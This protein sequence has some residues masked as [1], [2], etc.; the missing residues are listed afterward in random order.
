M[1]KIDPVVLKETKYIFIWVLLLS[2][3][4]Q[5]VFLIIGKWDYTVLLGNFLSGSAAVLNFLLMG[6]SIAK[7]LEKEVEDAKKAMKLS[8]SYRFLF[9]AAVVALGA[10][11]SCFNLWTVLIPLLFPRIAIAFRPLFEKE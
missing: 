5:S 2:A 10:T 11:L 7:A 9:L 4:M 3:L 1:K 6:I 8:Q